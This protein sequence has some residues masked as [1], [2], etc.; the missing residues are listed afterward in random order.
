M[1]KYTSHEVQNEIELMALR[2]LR[3]ICEFL[4]STEFYTVMIDECTDVSNQEQVAI[5]LRWVDDQ[6]TPHEEFIGL[7]AVPSIDSSMLVSIIKDTLVCMNLSLSK[8]RGQCFDGA[9][10][11]R[12]VRNGV[13][14]QLQDVE[15]QAI[16]IHCY[17][18]SL[19]LA[20]SDAIQHCKLMKTS[21]ETTHE[22]TKLE[23]YSPQREGLFDQIKGE[24]TPD[25]PDIRV[26]CPTRWTVH[27]ASMHS[28]IQN[29]S[30]LQE[31]WEKA[32]DVVRDT[33][34]I[35]C[36]QEDQ[37]ELFWEK[38]RKMTSELDVKKPQLPRRR[39]VPLR[40]ESGKAPAEYHSTPK[41]Y[42]LSSDLL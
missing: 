21:L 30:V 31:L 19:S 22:I 36:I 33:E 24:L 41:G 3:E 28:V 1:E 20:A 12:G 6:L 40:Y 25:G 13:A 35:A 15:S 9:S 18:H 32:V 5:I 34:T 2:V 11:T 7:Y 14:K 23:K 26:L 42:L 29:Y 16:Y 39:K 27:A 10:N 37:F 8:L 17:G 38:V 4:H